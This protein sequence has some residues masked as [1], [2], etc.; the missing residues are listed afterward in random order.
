[1][2]NGGTGL[3][4]FGWLLR[5]DCGLGLEQFCCGEADSGISA[6]EKYGHARFLSA[7]LFLK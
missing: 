3:P 2:V 4:R 1:L 7:D 6:N 5:L